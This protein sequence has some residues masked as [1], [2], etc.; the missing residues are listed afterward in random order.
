MSYQLNPSKGSVK[1]KKRIGRGN[2]SGQGR[3]AGKGHKGYKSRSGTKAKLHFEGG[4]T[5]LARRLP[6]RGMKIFSKVYRKKSTYQ[7]INLKDLLDLKIQK[8]NSEVLFEKGIIKKKD[9]PIKVLANGNFDKK[10]ELSFNMFS[11]NAIDKVEKA[12]GKV[13]FI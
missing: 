10:M 12:G 3:T 9:I 2:A 11:K 6:K 7:T 8:V 5:P 4:Q 1:N 13:I